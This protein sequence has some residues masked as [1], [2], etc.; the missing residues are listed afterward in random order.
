MGK[1]GNN[2]EVLVREPVFCLVGRR[3]MGGREEIPLKCCLLLEGHRVPIARGLIWCVD[4]F[5]LKKKKVFSSSLESE[6]V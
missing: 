1:T 2:S 3:R 6:P 5:W 4:T